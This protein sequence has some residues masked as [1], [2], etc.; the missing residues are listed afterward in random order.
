MNI[1]QAIGSVEIGL[2]YALVAI[3]V[4]LTFRIMDFPDLTVDGSFPLGAAIAI[5]LIGQGTDPAIATILAMFG[6]GVAG[7]ATAYMN[8]KLNI[9][10]LLAGIISMTALYSINLRIM[11]VPNIALMDEN[12]LFTD[13]SN[14][15]VIGAILSSILI[16]IGVFFKTEMGIAIRASGINTKVSKA[17]GVNVDYMKQITLALS[18]SIIALAGAIFAQKQ[19]FADISM[20][21]GTIIIGLA[22]VII[23]EA[24]GM[25]GQVIIS[26]IGCVI[27]SVIYRLIIALALNGNSIGLKAT[28]LNLVTAALVVAIMII[29]RR[30]KC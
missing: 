9:L 8:T 23:G 24:L 3:G 27:G 29:S 1:I 14:L 20:G 2:I 13:R 11:S 22:S 18:N 25:R 7:Y 6:G 5:S 26:L 21:S 28:D 10:G 30:K 19:G 16:A 12:T 4:Y 17:Y 15:L